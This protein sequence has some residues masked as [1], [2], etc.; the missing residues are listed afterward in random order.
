M[1]FANSPMDRMSEEQAFL[2]AGLI[3]L[4]ILL[5]ASLFSNKKN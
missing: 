3:L 4:A 5:V 2:T 1:I